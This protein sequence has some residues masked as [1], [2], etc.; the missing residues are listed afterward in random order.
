MIG[1][2]RARGEGGDL[3]VVKRTDRRK[4]VGT[5]EEKPERGGRGVESSERL[6]GRLRPT[7][8]LREEKTAIHKKKK[9]EEGRWQPYSATLIKRP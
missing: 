1:E 2:G 9:G 6:G 3:L 4:V 7:K 5:R 8:D